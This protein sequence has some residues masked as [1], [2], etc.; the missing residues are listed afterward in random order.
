MMVMLVIVPADRTDVDRANGRGNDGHSGATLGAT[1]ITVTVRP[2][3][4]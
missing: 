1:F 3:I 2:P 4:N